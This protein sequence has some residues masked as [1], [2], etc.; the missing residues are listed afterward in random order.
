VWISA[1]TG[2]PPKRYA[3]APFEADLLVNYPTMQFCRTA[4]ASCFSILQRDER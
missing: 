1:P 4:G 2:S 3:P